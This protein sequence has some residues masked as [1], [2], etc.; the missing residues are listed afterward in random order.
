MVVLRALRKPR[1]QGFRL[2]CVGFWGGDVC[3]RDAEFVLLGFRFQ[4]GVMM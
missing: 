2:R 4:F 3:F 1:V